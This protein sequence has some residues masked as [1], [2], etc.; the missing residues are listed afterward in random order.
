MG[1]DAN[2]HLKTMALGVTDGK[3]GV[4]KKIKN[5]PEVEALVEKWRLARRSGDRVKARKAYAKVV[6]ARERQ[7]N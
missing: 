3:Q 7:E 6:E 1:K 5:S 4:N 2:V